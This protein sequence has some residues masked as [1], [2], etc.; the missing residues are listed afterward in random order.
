M[1]DGGWRI[2]I[3]EV[4]SAERVWAIFLQLH[5]GG[6][7]EEVT[8]EEHAIANF[9]LI[10]VASKGSCGEGGLG[11]DQE[12]KSKPGAIGAV[13][14]LV[15]NKAFFRIP[16]GCLG[17]EREFKNSLQLFEAFP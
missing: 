8:A 5:K 6:L 15:P 3:G 17:G 11:F 12:H 10:E 4:Q 13:A 14:R 2:W 7:A 16:A 9:V 1:T